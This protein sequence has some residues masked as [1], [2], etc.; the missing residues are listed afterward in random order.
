MLQ[1]VLKIVKI[2]EKLTV[3]NAIGISTETP[4]DVTYKKYFLNGVEVK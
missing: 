2:H 3:S 1:K 4:R